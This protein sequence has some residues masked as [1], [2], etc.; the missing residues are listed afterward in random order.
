MSFD[1]KSPRNRIP[2]SFRVERLESRVLL[3]ADPVLTPL[4]AALMPHAMHIAALPHA[5]SAQ[6]LGF[7]AQMAMFNAEATGLHQSVLYP[8]QAVASHAAQDATV[9]TA[10]HAT[11]TNSASTASTF[12][13]ARTATSAASPVTSQAAVQGATTS[14]ASQAGRMHILASP[15]TTTTVWGSAT[16]TN[17]TVANSLEVNFPSNVTVTLATGTTSASATLGGGSTDWLFAGSATQNLTIVRTGTGTSSVSFAGMPSL[18]TMGGT[19]QFALQNLSIGTL[20]APVTNVTF[21]GDVNLTGNL[22]IYATGTVNFDGAVTITNNFSLTIVGANQVNF[23]G[24]VALNGTDGTGGASTPLAQAGNISIQANHITFPTGSSV[25]SGSGTLTLLPTT[26][27]NSILFA[28]PTGVSS[29]GTTLVIANADIAGWGSTFSSIAIGGST[30]GHADGFTSLISIGATQNFGLGGSPTVRDPITFYASA[31]NVVAAPPF[32]GSAFTFYGFGSVA[33]DAVNNIN[34]ANT[35]IADSSGGVA[36]NITAYSANGSITQGAA[37]GYIS[38]ADMTAT[39]VTGITLTDTLL[40]TLH[41]VNSGTT[42]SIAVTQIQQ[43]G[44]TGNLTVLQ[45][46]QTAGGSNGNISITTVGNGLAVS[47]PSYIQGGNLTIGGSGVTTAGSGNISLT[48]QAPASTL[49]VSDNVTANAGTIQLTAPGLVTIGALTSTTGGAVTATSS[50]G[51]ILVNA[52]VNVQAAGGLLTLSALT[53]DITMTAGSILSSLSNGNI[54]L[55]A[56]GNDVLATLKAG[57]LMSVTATAGSITSS[58]LESTLSAQLNFAGAGS[59]SKAFLS[60]AT[61]IGTRGHDIQT[62]LSELT[63]ANSTSGDVF[64]DQ[65][66][67]ADLQLGVL[68]SGVNAVTVG[69]TTGTTSIVTT[70]G[71]ITINTPVSATSSV[72]N[73]LIEASKQS[74][75]TTDVNVNANVTSASGSIE[76]EAARNVVVGTAAAV[77]I[78]ANG[79]N[80]TVYLQAVS[81]VT[82]FATSQ[83]DATG[84]VWVDATNGTVTLGE[85]E[86]SG[87]TVAIDAGNTIVDAQ[88]NA[89]QTV[90]NVMA[91]NVRMT[92]VSGIGSLADEVEISGLPGAGVTF[93]GTSTAAS[94]SAGIFV[95]ALS[96]MTVGSVGASLVNATGPATPASVGDSVAL[97]SVAVSGASNLVLMS[98][99]VM[100]IATPIG[101]AGPVTINST[102]VSTSVLLDA[103]QQLDIDASIGNTGGAFTS[104]TGNMRLLGVNGVTIGTVGSPVVINTLGGTLDVQ[105]DSASVQMNALSTLA[106]GTGSIRVSAAQNLGIAEVTTTSGNVSLIATAGSITDTNGNTTGTIGTANV[107]AVGLRLNAGTDIGSTTD[108]L[109]ANVATLSAAAA[110]GSVYVLDTAAETIGSVAVTVVAVTGGSSPGTITDAA[111]GGVATSGAN[112]NIVLQDSTGNMTV[113]TAVSA[114]G[115]GNV[116]LQS[117]VGSVR[118][119]AGVSSGSGDVSL[120]SGTFVAIG[121]GGT[122]QTISTGGTGTIDVAATTNVAMA[123]NSQV[124][125]GSGAIRL[126]GASIALARVSTTGNVSLL[127]TGATGTIADANGN[128]DAAVGTTNV[129]ASGLRISA[130]GVVGTGADALEL[131]VST[132]AASSSTGGLFLLDEQAAAVGS[133][134]TSVNRVAA[135]AATAAVA[136]A[137]LAGLT[138]LANG[139]I[140][141]QTT[142]GDLAVNNAV[143]ANGTL[144]GEGNVLLQSAA[145][146]LTLNANVDSSGSSTGNGVGSI[147]LL[148]ATGIAIASNVAT[149]TGTGTIDAESGA[150]VT[151]GAGSSLQS[152]ANVGVVAA[153]SI[154]VGTVQSSAAVALTANGGSITDAYGNPGSV[155]ENVIASAARLQASNGVGQSNDALRTQLTNLTASAGAGGVYLTSNQGETVSHATVQVNKVGQNG[156]VVTTITQ[157]LQN[158]V[159]TS[160]AGNVVLQATAGDI[161]LSPGTAA[162]A[163][164]TASG[165]G[166]VLVQAVVGAVDVNASV[167]SDAGGTGSGNITVLGAG[168][169]DLA[170]VAGNATL[171]TSTG[172]IDV[173]SSG[174][175][176][177]MAAGALVSDTNGAIRM[178]AQNIQV[179]EVAAGGNVSL[180]AT[181]AIADAN[182]NTTTGSGAVVDVQAS[183]LRLNAGTG[184]GT[185]GDALRTQVAT[186]SASA[187][188]GG[189]YVINDQALTVGSVAASVSKVG[190]DGTTAAVTDAAQFGFDAGATGNLVLDTTTGDLTLS[191]AVHAGGTGNVLVQA[192]AGNVLAN[193]NVASGSGAIGVFGS[194]GVVINSGAQVGS[195]GTLDIESSGGSVTMV[196][197]SV[198]SSDS[199]IRV[200]AL[201]SIGLAQVLTPLD[202]ALTATNG[203]IVD[204]NGNTDAA[205]GVQDVQSNG[206]RLFA[207]NR[208]GSGTDAL[209]VQVNTLSENTGAGGAFVVGDQ[210]IIVGT[211]SASVSQVGLDG[212][213]ATAS[214]AAQAGLVSRSNGDLVLQAS[215][216]DVTL[217]SASPAVAAVNAN[218]SGDILVQSLAGA[219]DADANVVSAGG[220]G[221]GNITVLGAAGVD[222]GANGVVVTVGS[223]AGTIDVESSAGAVAMSAHSVLASGSVDVRVVAATDIA[224]GMIESG[225]NVALTAGGSIADANGNSNGSS[226]NILNVQAS[227]LRLNAGLG[228][229]TGTDALQVQ[230]DTLAAS[231][232]NHGLFLVDDQTLAVGS[233]GT[234]VD[235]LGVSGFIAPV[236]DAALSGIVAVTGGDV[237]LQAS[238]GDL[239]IDAAIAAGG[240]ANV[241]LQSVGGTVDVDA[242]V[243]DVGST[244][245]TGSIS[246][247]GAAGVNVA[248]G[249]AV[250]DSNLGAASLDVESSNGSVQMAAG[251]TLSASSVRVV[252]AQ[253]IGLGQ[254]LSPGNVALTA[255]AGTI[256][257]ATHAGN[258]VQAA[259]LYLSAGTAAGT[260]ANALQT[261]VATL[262]AAVGN[263]GMDV[264]NDQAFATNSVSTTIDK[265]GLDGNAFAVTTATGAD[266]IAS[267]GAVTLEATAGDIALNSVN[268]GVA[269]INANGSGSVLVEAIAGSIAVNA[270]VLD[271]SVNT[272][273]GISLLAAQGVTIGAGAPVSIVDG[274]GAMDIEAFDG[275]IAM[276]AGSALLASVGTLRVVAE[277]SVALGIVQATGNTL[278]QAVTGTLAAQSDV[279][280]GA[281]T[282]TGTLTLH[283]AQDVTVASGVILSDGV[284]AV[285]ITSDLGNVTLATSSSLLSAGGT[286]NVVAAKSVATGLVQAT[287]NTLIQAQGGTLALNNNVTDGAGAQAGTL[288]LLATGDI[289]A[290]SGVALGDGAGRVD[291]E[292]SAGNVTL[293]ANSTLSSDGGTVNV[294][295]AQSI[296]LGQLIANANTRVEAQ[297]G[298]IAVDNTL[299]VGSGASAGDLSLLALGDVDIA[300]GVTVRSGAGSMDIESRAASLEMNAT[301]QLQSASGAVHVA[302]GQDVEVSRI[303]TAGSVALTAIAGNIGDTSGTVD[304]A[305]DGLLLSAGDGIALAIQA[306]TVAA[307]SGGGGI[308]L[309]SD[310]GVT[311]GTVSVVS[312]KVSTTGT[313]SPITDGAQS[314][315]VSASNG[316]ISLQATSGD[317]TLTPAGGNAIAAQGSGNVLV[318][319]LNPAGNVNAFAGITSGTGNVDVEA[320]DNITLYTANSAAA[321]IVTALPGLVTVHAINGT[322]FSGGTTAP[323]QT[324]NFN[325]DQLTLQAPLTGTDNQLNIGPATV[326]SNPDAV[327]VGGPAAGAGSLYLSQDQIGLIQTGFKD[328]DIGSTIPGQV[329]SLVGQDAGGNASTNVFVNPLT[330]TASGAGGTVAISGGLQ[331]TSLDVEGSRTGTTLASATVATSGAIVVNDNVI[332]TG[333]TSLTSGTGAAAGLTVN[334]S[335]TGTGANSLALSANG[336]NIVVTGAVSGLG[337]LTVTQAASLTFQSTLSVTGN[338]VINTT[339]AI[340]FAGGVT[341]AA[342]GTLT[343]NGATSV[344]FASTA[345]FTQ[346]GSVKISTTALN[347]AGGAGSV[348]GVGNLTLQGPTASAPIHLG[349]TVVAGALNIDA[350]DVSAIA[351]GFQQVVIGTVDAST[352]HASTTAGAVDIDGSMSL[353]AFSSPLAIYASTITVDAGGTGVHVGGPLVLDAVG[354]IQIG[355]NVTTTVAANVSLTSA[356]STVQMTAQTAIATLGGN[357]TVTTG[358]SSNATLSVIDTRATGS[359]VG[360][361]VAIDVQNGRVIDANADSS[362]NVYGAAV[363]M[364]G[365]G[366]TDTPGSSQ[367][368]VLKVRAPVVY[369]ASPTGDVVADAGQDGRTNYNALDHGTLYEELISV[370]ATTRVTLPGDAVA[371]GGSEA[372]TAGTLDVSLIHAAAADAF[373]SRLLST[374]L[375]SADADGVSLG[376]ATADTAEPSGYVLGSMSGHPSV[377]GVDSY[378]DGAVDWWTESLEV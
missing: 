50:A 366:I 359:D 284:G 170:L 214:D 117:S 318:D 19:G 40:S 91:A 17:P 305:A 86:S 352:G 138:T 330:L 203:S 304:V 74:S 82:F 100:T 168:G 209:Q 358:N 200:K 377:S 314:G 315:L 227:G 130:G 346:A 124:N 14:L 299:Q 320:G 265:V 37:S 246:V 199:D 112:G 343:I 56:G 326:A 191:D 283:G 105:A 55:V 344:T 61:G 361:V 371:G 364:K 2:E 93:A 357:V 159:N 317:I 98:H 169:V 273:G 103:A 92:S 370:G 183:G 150:A 236:T 290:A 46:A 350:Q 135:S 178:A 280:V 282:Q 18:A 115:S 99:G 90:A 195:A 6:Q 12:A 189:A 264:V 185:S 202:V 196:A 87:G 197:G 146:A 281:G 251:S 277:D 48:T 309:V 137:A 337:A 176:V 188:A 339:G 190:L 360:A 287:G 109:Q 73:L 140:V 33:F 163:A 45:A 27:G 26:S 101:L 171:G 84:N 369:V 156:T 242:N 127:A 132:I 292:S 25:F 362:V 108:E 363:S 312:N 307:S 151:M 263:G 71:A 179:G 216:G 15:P 232:G 288:T 121:N 293:A 294:N 210:S 66:Q 261:Q 59:S 275:D 155:V 3:S 243:N 30:A 375:L 365:Y 333:A 201:A 253:D 353:A 244:G 208:I 145:G 107:Q 23:A 164:I 237:V 325:T 5:A 228:V 70:D 207:G 355:S 336:G 260:G 141:L 173:E 220:S 16:Q 51:S 139:N 206:L 38:A 278:V 1:K 181:G 224:V 122:P 296:A 32:T 310:Q 223:G 221:S 144:N 215:A 104:Y 245:A 254:V 106:S 47:D 22:V 4:A 212:G 166:N 354:Q 258:N 75:S 323:G 29:S 231:V 198:L 329:V 157:A 347:F 291:V 256:S 57:G 44:T 167:Y 213:L 154:A 116:L 222:I 372:P 111:Q 64:V 194:A 125:A 234:T 341:I 338:V 11:A 219:V 53:G 316:N 324:V 267:S 327:V 311:V 192:Q 49:T 39:A 80:Q 42:G 8:T 205:T 147:S 120:S 85:I 7:A 131:Q 268:V 378:G 165:G 41:A 187:L 114:N 34:I 240:N 123:A 119:N 81:N 349:S 204:D 76:I 262:S 217:T 342:G 289:V 230:I 62:Q 43:L 308:A 9:T 172:S 233:V 255:T 128:T 162:Q 302:A 89:S 149:Q 134:A 152:A 331:A 238:S 94:T 52:N 239:D 225:D 274:A 276:G 334:G 148:G 356:T 184:V 78:A 300:A 182:G 58:M 259:G 77:T 24:A 142:A 345:D 295:A 13:A 133:V 21:N 252:A 301:S 158:G 374:T 143:N 313:T 367:N 102:P 153:T 269:A 175:N 248:A 297:A 332:V 373:M 348:R 270:S 160:A 279:R 63:L 335:I 36:Q 193:A 28:D 113:S 96:D 68:G 340:D 247:I 180:T 174:G 376:G 241:L 266:A 161:T 10:S 129:T 69:G 319:A 31:I 249:I 79:A 306:N 83:L 211:V 110:A 60:A 226:G 118:V 351:S 250:L 65:T 271:G 218:G 54:T 272:A 303:A 298:S 321:Q 328:V 20:A 35:V 126:S 95:H 322:V 72:G 235:Q 286:V 257:N 67:L 229:G 186:L 97:S 88:D 368:S 285:A 136:D 177:A